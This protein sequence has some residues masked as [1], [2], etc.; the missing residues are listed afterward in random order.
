[1]SDGLKLE[2]TRVSVCVE[3]GFL[4]SGTF[5]HIGKL[6]RLHVLIT[7]SEG[8][9]FVL[10]LLYDSQH[11]GDR[12]DCMCWNQWKEMLIHNHLKHRHFTVWWILLMTDFLF[13][14][15][16]INPDLSCLSF[17]KGKR[18]GNI[19]RTWGRGGMLKRPKSACF[20]IYL[21]VWCRSFRSRELPVLFSKIL[22]SLSLL[23][24][25]FPF[26]SFLLL[27]PIMTVLVCRT[28]T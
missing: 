28:L 24:S 25:D 6:N 17:K 3:P 27:S 11:S 12:V 19:N 16:S 13:F 23:M 8:Q 20:S 15:G 10:H 14:F 5:L 18:K 21:F 2:K 26:K 4:S 1:M 9:I 22:S 7:A